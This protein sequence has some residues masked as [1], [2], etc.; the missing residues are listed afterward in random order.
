ME[1]QLAIFG[2]IPTRETKKHPKYDLPDSVK[3][4]VLDILNSGN[5]ASFY[6]GTYVQKYEKTFANRFNR[7]YGIATNSGTSALHIAYLSCELPEFSEVLVPANC[8]I[9]AI[10]AL[11]QCNLVPVIVDIDRKSWVMDPLDIERKISEKTS[12][13]VPVHMYG[14]P[15]PMDKITEIAKKYNLKI[16]EDCGQS[17][18]GTWNGRLTG[19]FGDVACFSTCCRK[20][21]TL[22]EGGMALTNSQ[23]MYA[24]AKAYCHK[25]KGI[26]WFDYL[27]MGYSYNLTEIQA[28]IGIYGVDNLEKEFA[29]RQENAK[30]LIKNLSDLD[31]EL[32]YIPQNSQHAYF[33]FNYLLPQKLSIH[34]DEIVDALK[35]ENIGADPS[36]PNVLDI[37]WLKN[38]QPYLFSQIVDKNQPNYKLENVPVATD[39]LKRQI[40]LEV[41]P[42]LNKHDMELTA[43]A[44][45][46]VINYYLKMRDIYEK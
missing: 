8:Y 18:G 25:G 24:L 33:K 9:S 46:K 37:G 20:H 35:A 1:N 38:K 22:G 29:N 7:K 10:S 45:K 31:I 41:G 26:G 23:K 43:K 11:I 39:I 2:G 16:I 30:V 13:I 3:E 17:H 42:G 27:Y 15:C 44:V 28:A 36:H 40:G 6:G 32:P 34:R 5:L 21:I 14:Q 4:T 12:A 19:T